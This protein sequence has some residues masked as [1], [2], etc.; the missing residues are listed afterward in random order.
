MENAILIIKFIVQCKNVPN[1]CMVCKCS[2]HNKIMMLHVKKV[3]CSEVLQ[4]VQNFR[5]S[6]KIMRL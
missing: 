4:I 1:I 2:E 3:L 5:T 6:F